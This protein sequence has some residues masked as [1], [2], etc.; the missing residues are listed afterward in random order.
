MELFVFELSDLC[1]NLFLGYRLGGKSHL[2]RSVQT[3]L[4]KHSFSMGVRFNGLNLSPKLSAKISDTPITRG[5]SHR[6]LWGNLSLSLPQ[7]VV[8]R[9]IWIRIFQYMVNLALL[10]LGQD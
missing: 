4:H 1:H 7:I 3:Q 5:I 6:S 10:V 8:S 9:C 2:K